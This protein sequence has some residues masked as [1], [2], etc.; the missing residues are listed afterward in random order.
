MKIHRAILTASSGSLFFDGCII[1]RRLT[2]KVTGAPKARPVDRRV[3]H[4]GRHSRTRA[5]GNDGCAVPLTYDYRVRVQRIIESLWCYRLEVDNV[6]VSS[7]HMREV[8]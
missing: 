3:R 7:F 6:E 1:T 2:I 5:I 8:H 4:H